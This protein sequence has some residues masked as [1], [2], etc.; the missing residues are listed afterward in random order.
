[1]RESS[2]EKLYVGYGNL[3]AITGYTRRAAPYAPIYTPCTA[4]RCRLQQYPGNILTLYLLGYPTFVE[5]CTWMM[6]DAIPA[7]DVAAILPY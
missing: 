1:M 5:N 2:R 4:A 7:D 6:A 3:A